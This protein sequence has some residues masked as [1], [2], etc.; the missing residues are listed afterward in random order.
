[1]H[2]G[3]VST[4]REVSLSV[5]MAH[6]LKPQVALRNSAVVPGNNQLTTRHHQRQRAP[7][8]KQGH[9]CPCE[10]RM[11]SRQRKG[12][13]SDNI[14][15]RPVPS[16]RDRSDL[17]HSSSQVGPLPLLAHRDSTLWLLVKARGQC[18]RPCQDI[19]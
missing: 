17:S 9:A 1:M 14:R 3:W 4:G 13:M 8:D 6:G 12:I 10:A 18:R 19:L 2:K 11:G 5:H 16:F 15:G 7:V